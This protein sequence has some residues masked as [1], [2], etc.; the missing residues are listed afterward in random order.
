MCWWYKIEKSELVDIKM[1]ESVH[2]Q[3]FFLQFKRLPIKNV[4]CKNLSYFQSAIS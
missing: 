1:I 2:L 3:E 4:T